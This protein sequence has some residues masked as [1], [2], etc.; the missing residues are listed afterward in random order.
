MLI[1]RKLLLLGIFISLTT[2]INLKAKLTIFAD[3]YIPQIFGNQIEISSNVNRY[4][5]RTVCNFPIE[6]DNLIEITLKKYMLEKKSQMGFI[7]HLELENEE[8]LKHHIYSTPYTWFCGSGQ[9]IINEEKDTDQTK[10]TLWSSY[11][12]TEE[13]HYLSPVLTEAE[14]NDNNDVVGCWLQIPQEDLV[15]WK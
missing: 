14:D 10:R 2:C 12:I 13:S 4:L 9:P 8:G 6:Q 5:N 7:A 15:E 11:G 1:T 3:D